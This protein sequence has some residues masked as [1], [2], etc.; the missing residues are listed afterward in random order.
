VGVGD[1]QLIRPDVAEHG[2][3]GLHCSSLDVGAGV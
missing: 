3:Y 2:S 1:A